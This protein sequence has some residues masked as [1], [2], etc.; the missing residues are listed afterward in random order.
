MQKKNFSIQFLICLCYELIAC[1]LLLNSNNV[2]FTSSVIAKPSVSITFFF[3][4]KDLAQNL[5]S[6]SAF[7]V[8]QQEYSIRRQ[9]F[10]IH[11]AYLKAL[12]ANRYA[13]KFYAPRNLNQSIRNANVP[14][15]K[16]NKFVKISSSFQILTV[17]QSFFKFSE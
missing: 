15:L 10:L 17:F 6:F 11:F 7:V 3:F 2:Y 12:N 13:Y 14:P 9:A 4:V 8:F 1:P 5:R 16:Q